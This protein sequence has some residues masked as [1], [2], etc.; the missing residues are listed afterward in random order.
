MT[1]IDDSSRCDYF[2]S[3]KSL[4]PAQYCIYPK[5]SNRQAWANSVDLN[6]NMASNQG[7]HGLLLIQLFLDISK[8]SKVDLFK[9][10]DKYGKELK[11]PYDAPCT[12]GP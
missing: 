12:K 2:L 3:I 4:S 11:C 1:N 8:C 10:Y 5:Y 9:V 6:Q 7:L